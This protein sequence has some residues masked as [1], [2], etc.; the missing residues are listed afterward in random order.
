MRR[1]AAVL[2]GSVSTTYDRWGQGPPLLLLS[3][4]AGA[5]ML[6]EEAFASASDAF[7][8]IVPRGTPWADENT[9]VAFSTWLRD[10]LDGL[11]VDRVTIVAVRDAGLLALLFAQLEPDRVERL[12]LIAVGARQA[13]HGTTLFPD[14]LERARVHLLTV[15]GASGN[16]ALALGIRSLQEAVG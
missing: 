16:T 5:E 14:R 15:A 1:S 6:S 2:A 4:D 8:V 7:T 3:A 13:V 10:F 11:G 9:Q 12:V